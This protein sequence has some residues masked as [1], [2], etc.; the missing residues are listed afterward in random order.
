MEE[1]R[2]QSSWSPTYTLT[3]AGTVG[4]ALNMTG[5]TGLVC[6]SASGLSC[7]LQVR[8]VG[9]GSY[10]NWPCRDAQ[11]G[12]AYA[13][14][15]TIASAAQKVIVFDARNVSDVQVTYVSGAGANV[16]FGVNPGNAPDVLSKVVQSAGY[17]FQLTP[18]ISAS[19]DYTAG[20]VVG[21]IQSITT[22]NSSSGRSVLLK[23]IS[24]KDKNGQSPALSFLF[25]KSTP[26]GG[27]YTD[28]AALVLGSGDAAN[29]VG[30]VRVVAGDNYVPVSGTS[31]ATLGAVDQLLPVTAS[32]LFCL[33]LADATWNA[34]STSDLTVD[35]GFEHR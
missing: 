8:H 4:Q 34:A 27:T 7:T 26:S 18:T 30:C 3:G 19:P 23:S 1:I 25:F 35:L 2:T 9:S 20:D 13:A 22:V 28:N 6:F 29:M 32:T 33:I 11:D 12:T 14:G 10:T 24:V 17:S 31:V 5:N 15:A 21:G 16:Q